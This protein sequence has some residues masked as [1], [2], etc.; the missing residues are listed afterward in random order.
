MKLI[1]PLSGSSS[2][3]V[4]LV[5]IENQEYV[6]KTADI[7]EIENEHEF[8]R[9]LYLYHIP[10]LKTFQNSNLQ[11]N[12]ILLEYIPNSPTLGNH[13]TPQLCYQWGVL[14]SQLH[15]I[16]SPHASYFD[17]TLHTIPWSDFISNEIHA[18]YKKDKPAK[19]PQEL[20]SKIISP[21]LSQSHNHYSLLHGDCHSNNVLIKN[22]YLILF[23]KASEI[24]FG[25]PAYDLAIIALEFPHERYATLGNPEHAQ[26]SMYLHAFIQGYGRD[27]TQDTNFDHYVLLRSVIREPNPFQP[28]LSDVIDGLVKKFI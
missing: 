3:T 13:L 14:M 2:S 1:R 20:L 23:D 16:Q 15:A 18:R 5:T 10:C 27:F 9:H 26:D 4:S 17:S 8:N 22:K 25:D 7:T 28:Y 19:I 12:Q 6:L 24:V 11:S 21:V